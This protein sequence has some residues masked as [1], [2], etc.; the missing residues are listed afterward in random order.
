M[1]GTYLIFAVAVF[2]LVLIIAPGVALML[3]LYPRRRDLQLP[4][5]LALIFLLGFTPQLLLYFLTKNMGVPVTK[6]TSYLAVAAVTACGLIVW[7]MRLGEAAVED[8]PR[9]KPARKKKKK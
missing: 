7:R 1:V 9:K 4:Q 5:Q 6:S 3:A 2:T 8:R